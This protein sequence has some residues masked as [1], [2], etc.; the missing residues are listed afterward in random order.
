MPGCFDKE[1]NPIRDDA[2]TSRIRIGFLEGLNSKKARFLKSYR[3][4]IARFGYN[5]DE[6]ASLVLLSVL[7]RRPV[8]QDNRGAARLFR[9]R[10][11]VSSGGISAGFHSLKLIF[12]VF[13]ITDRASAQC[14]NLSPC[15]TSGHKKNQNPSGVQILQG[16]GCP[17]ILRGAAPVF[18]PS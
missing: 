5:T 11:L 7:W 16:S 1:Q 13:I 2:G 18:L 10:L 15:H 6:G 3:L 12:V 9:L 14:Y 4:A 8:R 17:R